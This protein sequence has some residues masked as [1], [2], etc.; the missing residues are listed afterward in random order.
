MVIGSLPTVI[1]YAKTGQ[2]NVVAIGS[3]ERVAQLPD[4][5]TI[6]S[7]VP[8]YVS[9]SCIGMMVPKG[10]PAPIFA[11]VQTAL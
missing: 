6:G 9:Y 5:P 8:G 2:A 3:K 11:H 1:Q 4:V 7:V 10:V